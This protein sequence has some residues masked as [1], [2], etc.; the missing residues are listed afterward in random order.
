MAYIEKRGN[1]QWRVQIRRKGYP[2][3]CKTFESKLDAEKWARDIE[4]EMDKG[5][6]VSRT[7]AEN[8]TLHEALERYK[9]EYVPRLSQQKREKNRIAFLQKRDLSTRFM[10]SIRGKDM[11][12]KFAV[13]SWA[14]KTLTAATPS[15]LR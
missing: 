13:C 15:R 10:A 9:D 8:T 7:E 5:V 11:P 6:F 3:T 4:N 1:L 2:T 14:N 12:A